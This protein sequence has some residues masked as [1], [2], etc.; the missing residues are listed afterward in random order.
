M[1]SLT[2]P[3]PSNWIPKTALAYLHNRGTPPIIDWANWPTPS[4]TIPKP[5]NSI[6]NVPCAYCNRGTA[7]NRLGQLANALSDYTKAMEF[8]PKCA[9]AFYARGIVDAQMGKTDEAEKDLQKAVELD[10]SFREPV[11]ERHLTIFQLGL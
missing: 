5:S 6:P 4:L 11:E 3:K 1:P 7:Y 8:D 10:P 2:M 9:L